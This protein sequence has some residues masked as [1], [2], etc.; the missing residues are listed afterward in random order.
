MFGITYFFAVK[1]LT[2]RLVFIYFFQKIT[3]FG[4]L[5]PIKAASF[6]GGVRYKRY[7]GKREPNL[8]DKS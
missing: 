5:A 1:V 2:I 8:A 3:V 7:S 4:S 6:C